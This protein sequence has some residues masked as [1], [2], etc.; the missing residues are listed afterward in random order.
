MNGGSGVL[1][2]SGASAPTHRVLKSGVIAALGLLVLG[3]YLLIFRPMT[4]ELAH[5][6][7]ELDRTHREIAEIGMGY[8]ENPGE[9]L[10]NASLKLERMQKLF[11]D[12]SEHVVFHSGIEELLES[13]FRVL[14]FEQRRF[15]IQQ[16]LRG[17]AAERGSSLPDDLFRGL[18]SYSE[19]IEPPQRLWMHLEFFNHV[20]GALLSSG[21]G[22]RVERIESLPIKALADPTEGD[23]SRMKLR[24][25][26][27]VRG[28]FSSLATFLNASLPG[29]E[30]AGS[31]LTKK[32]YN[33]ERLDL[34]S[35]RDRGE[36]A[37][38][39]DAMLS[40]FIF[41]DQSD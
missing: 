20:V 9:Y 40:G 6:D 7:A 35:D 37:V 30:G 38:V 33:I 27:K 16:S 24:I 8:P 36:G 10:D 32:A 28:P 22:L 26:L 5:L 2:G 19:T 1:T 15:D 3:L 18:P 4:D 21:A 12:L 13:P 39:L 23:L 14:E 31:S 34:R 11:G 29:G 41:S 25:R 17:L